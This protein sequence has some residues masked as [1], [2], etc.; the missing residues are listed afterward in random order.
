MKFKCEKDSLLR[1]ISLCQGVLSTR[2]TLP[3]LSYY[4]FEAK[5]G[6]LNISATDLEV[7]VTAEI[8]SEIIEEGGITLPGKRVLD[9][10]REF[11]SGEISLSSEENFTTIKGQKVWVKISSLSTEDFPQ[12]PEVKGKEIRIESEKLKNMIKKTSFSVS[13]EESRYT[14]NG[15]YMTAHEKVI[16]MVSTDG[17]RLSCITEELLTPC[18]QEM[19]AILPLKAGQ[20]LNRVM[21]EGEVEVVWGEKQMKFTQPGITLTT[22]LIEGEFPDYKKVIPKSFKGEGKIDKNLF[23]EAVKRAYIMT[24]EKGVSVRLSFSSHK[25]K[26]TTR[27]PEIGE[28][29]EDLEMEYNGEDLEIAFDPVFILDVLKVM[30]SEKVIMGINGPLDPAL[31]RPDAGENYLYVVM[32]MKI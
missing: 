31:I 23:E 24:R 8:K 5:G 12:F 18:S 25:L 2:S 16:S 22:R 11:P 28:S 3:I 17:R 19:E 32:P 30:E 4:L 10:I 15:I 20:E 6:I 29:S 9:L 26:L 7:G 27:V 21:E 1:G 13:H 14:L